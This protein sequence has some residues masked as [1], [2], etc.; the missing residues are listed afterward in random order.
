MASTPWDGPDSAA[1]HCAHP[2]PSQMAIDCHL[3]ARIVT[4]RRPVPTMLGKPAG[5]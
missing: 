1:G 5:P 2:V 4:D 3:A